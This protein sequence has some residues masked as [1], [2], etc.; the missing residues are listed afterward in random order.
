MLF[1]TFF[2]VS[3][4]VSKFQYSDIVTFQ[5]E[6]VW[7]EGCFVFFYTLAVK[8]CFFAPG[9]MTGSR[10]TIKE[11]DALQFNNNKLIIYRK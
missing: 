9:V 1:C 5:S 4:F 8:N 2:F 7:R 6:Q 3:L 11:G 10:A